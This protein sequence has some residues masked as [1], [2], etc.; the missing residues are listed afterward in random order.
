M[1]ESQVTQMCIRDC[2][3]YGT[4]LR[5]GRGRSKQANY[6]KCQVR[7]VLG[8]NR[9]GITK[10]QTDEPMS[11]ATAIMVL[12]QRLMRYPMSEFYIDTRKMFIKDCVQVFHQAS[13][14]SRKN[15]KA[16]SVI[17]IISTL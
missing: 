6:G 14:F 3:V 2:F 7:E 15:G 9:K 8:K 1:R 11:M 13:V 12:N 10:Y 16:I 17:E 5:S 4:T